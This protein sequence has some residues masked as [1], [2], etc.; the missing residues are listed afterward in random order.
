MTLQRRYRLVL[1]KRRGIKG[2]EIAVIINS[3]Y[4]D[5][6]EMNVT[7]TSCNN[8]SQIAETLGLP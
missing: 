3:N 6:E 4:P 2:F 8:L 5:N 1:R 7:E